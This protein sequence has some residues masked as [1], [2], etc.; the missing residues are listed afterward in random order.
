MRIKFA[1]VFLASL[2][3]SAVTVSCSSRSGRSSSS[4]TQTEAAT[5]ETTSSETE[6]TVSHTEKASVTEA[7]SAA[8]T[9]TKPA[10]NKTTDNP[11]GTPGSGYTDS[12]TLATDFYQAYLDH[13]PE[14]VYKMFDPEEI[15][16]Y[17][18]LIAEELDGK[19]PDEVFSEDAVIKAID[20]SMYMIEEIMAEFSDS[21]NDRW[22]VD[23]TEELLTTA[24]GDAISVFNEELGTN[25]KK[26]TVLQYMYYVNEDNGELF[27]GNSSAYLEKNGQWYVSFSSLM[28]SE[29]IDQLE[30]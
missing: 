26:G 27:M 23:I 13:E 25:Y 18:K 1:A 16:C 15:E 10:V 24:E 3:V 29:L 22:S 11:T 21:E 9:T 28:Q 19:S 17:K 6:T 5:A 12:L 7:A 30:V 20:G 2:L 14:K 8:I 4:S